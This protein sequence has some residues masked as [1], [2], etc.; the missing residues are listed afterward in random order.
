MERRSFSNSARPPVRVRA[1]A[2]SADR[3]RH[4]SARHLVSHTLASSLSPLEVPGLAWRYT[5]VVATLAWP[6]V[7]ATRDREHR[8]RGRG[9]RG[10]AAANLRRQLRVETGL[11]CEALDQMIDRSV[12]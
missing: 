5:L 6:R 2:A 9:S 12:R 11:K 7:L 1:R 8:G 3:L 10:H 4:S